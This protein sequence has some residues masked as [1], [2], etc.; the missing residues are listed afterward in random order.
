M[1]LNRE[2][3]PSRSLQSAFRRLTQ[4]RGKWTK[5]CARRPTNVFRRGAEN[6]ER[7]ARALQI[8]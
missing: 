8:N 1:Q 7:D 6:S 3:D 4:V 5:W 2:R